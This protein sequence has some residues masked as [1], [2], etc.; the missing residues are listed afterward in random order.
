MKDVEGTDVVE[1][2]A[3]ILVGINIELDGDILTILNVELTNA[4]FAKNTEHHATRILAG[5][6]QH[7]ILRHP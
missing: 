2:A 5:D 3:L 7:V 6:F 1:P 4:V